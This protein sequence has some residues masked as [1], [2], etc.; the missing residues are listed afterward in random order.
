[1]TSCTAGVVGKQFGSS[2]P[3]T[4]S[5]H[6]TSNHTPGNLLNNQKY[7]K[8]SIYKDVCSVF[9][10]VQQEISIQLDVMTEYLL[11]APCNKAEF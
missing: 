3:K 7:V 5:H 1:M 4:W 8:S 9:E 6:V 2:E 11:G 10:R